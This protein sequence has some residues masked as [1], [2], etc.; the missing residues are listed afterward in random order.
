MNFPFSCGFCAAS[1]VLELREKQSQDGEKSPI[2][3]K[4]S[5]LFNADSNKQYGRRDNVR[6]FGVKEEA[7]EDV[8]Q[9]VV[10]VDMKKGHQISKTD[11]NICHRVPSRNLKKDEGRPLIVKFV[12][13]QTKS[14]PMAN[15]KSL[16]D[17]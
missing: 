13:R 9:K 15:K 11:I 7:D 4:L 1:E 5:S 12:R 17:F 6:K 2:T 16:K 10:D 14:G 3:G 8:Y